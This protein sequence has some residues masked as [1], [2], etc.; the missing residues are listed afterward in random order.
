MAAIIQPTPWARQPGGPVTANRIRFPHLVSFWPLNDVGTVPRDVAGFNTAASSSGVQQRTDPRFGKTLF[1]SG[2]DNV[3]INS[4]T[5]IATGN[6]VLSISIWGKTTQTISSPRQMIVINNSSG[7]GSTA[8]V[9]LLCKNDNTIAAFKESGQQL[10]ASGFSPTIGRWFH[11]G[12]TWD[13]TTNRIYINGVEAAN[14]TTAHSTGAVDHIYI[15]DYQAGGNESWRGD[16]ALPA[17]F[18][19]AMTPSEIYTLYNE[20]FVLCAPLPRRVFAGPSTTGAYTLTADAGAFTLT[21]QDATLTR[22]KVLTADAGSFTLSGQDATL[23]WGRILTADAG[24]FTLTGQDATLSYAPAG[25]YTLVADAGAFTLTGQDA[26]L[27]KTRILTADAGSFSLSGQSAT[28]TWSGEPIV[29]TPREPQPGY[30]WGAWVRKLGGPE[31]PYD[32]YQFTNR[33]FKDKGNPYE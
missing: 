22:D 24:S 28:L 32:A 29:S 23:T 1:Y 17:I 13:G 18:D 9:Q 3:R 11:V 15:G 30:D 27:L 26:T 12:Y 33:R 8:A 2:N 20:P 25:S 6:S 16:L 7:G 4:A 19:V 10:V 31:T 21:G 5:G 14:S